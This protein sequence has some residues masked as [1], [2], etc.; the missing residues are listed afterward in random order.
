M[1]LTYE[2]VRSRAMAIRRQSGI[3]KPHRTNLPEPEK[4]GYITRWVDR[5]QIS[6]DSMVAGDFQVPFFH[7]EASEKLLAVA[8]KL[9]IKTLTIGGDF[10]DVPYWSRFDVTAYQHKLNWDTDK[11]LGRELLAAFAEWFDLIYIVADNHFRRALRKLDFKSSMRG[12]YGDVVGEALEEKI[13]ASDYPIAEINKK[14]LVI[15]PAAYRQLKLS[16]ASDLAMKYRK[17]CFN[18][19]GHLAAK[20]FSKYGD[21]IIVDGACMTDAALHEYVRDHPTAHPDWNVGFYALKD[22]WPLEFWFHEDF[23]WSY[24]LGDREANPQVG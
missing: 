11:R 12:L 5:L 2:A 8:Q 13:I 15:H 19:H 7:Y 1:G 21:Y 14:W 9:N 4:D 24:W 23:P 17:N 20:G 10:F 16:L 18:F 3:P 22:N 6:G